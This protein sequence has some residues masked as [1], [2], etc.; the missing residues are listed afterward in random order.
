MELKE[1]N[2]ILLCNRIL[3]VEDKYTN[4]YKLAWLKIK[5]YNPTVDNLDEMF[6]KE[7]LFEICS[8]GNK[9]NLKGFLSNPHMDEW[10]GKYIVGLF[11]FDDAYECFKNMTKVKDEQLKWQSIKGCEKEGLYSSRVKYMNVSALV[12]PVPDYRKNIANQKHSVNRLE[13]EL[14]FKDEDIEEMYGSFGFA[15]ENVISDIEIPKIIIRK[16]F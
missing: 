6:K 4:I 14:L 7:S 15:K 12:L 2:K 16:I 3:F 10:V 1:E 5:G 11:D 9:D 8:K 13:V